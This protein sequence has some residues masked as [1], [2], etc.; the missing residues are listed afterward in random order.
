MSDDFLNVAT[1][2]I[3]EGLDAIKK[4][5]KNC[6]NDTDIFSNAK[7]IQRHLH[8]IKGL[9]PMMGQKEVGEIA[10]ITDSLAK[11]A[12]ANGPL[13]KSLWAL[14]ESNSIMERILCGQYKEDVLEYKKKIRKI[15]SSVLK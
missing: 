6:K 4:I 7:E 14:L 1:K 9:A 2:E 13:E 10:K 8:K 5:L 3:Q 15:F 12:I 11:H